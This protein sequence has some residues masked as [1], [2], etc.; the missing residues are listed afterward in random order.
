MMIDCIPE[1][2]SD[3]S[4]KILDLYLVTSETPNKLPDKFTESIRDE[5]PKDIRDLNEQYVTDLVKWASRGQRSD[6]IENRYVWEVQAV[7]AIHREIQRRIKEN[8]DIDLSKFE[9]V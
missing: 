7:A 1:L 9:V 5:T 3:I 4:R 6:E 8:P 2:Y